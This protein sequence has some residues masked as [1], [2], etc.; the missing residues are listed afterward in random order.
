MEKTPAVDYLQ[1]VYPRIGFLSGITITGGEPTLHDYLPDFLQELKLQ[2]Y[3]IKLDTNASKPKRLQRLIERELVDYFSVFLV[4]PIHKY[5]EV[6]R[7][8]IKPEIMRKSIQIIRKSEVPREW[9]VMPV[10]GINE[11]EDIEAISQSIAGARRL[12]IRK[13]KHKKTLDPK[14]MDIE[15][16]SDED[17][18]EIRDKVAPYFHEVHIEGLDQKAL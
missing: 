17:L 12:V 15:P 14:C 11:V 3:K 6:A 4:A 7:Y 2:G 10:P 1:M 9:V 13:F 5:P 16:F 8:R 18:K